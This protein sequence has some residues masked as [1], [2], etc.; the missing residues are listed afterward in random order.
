VARRTLRTYPKRAYDCNLQ[1]VSGNGGFKA[2][3]GDR[4]RVSKKKSKKIKKTLSKRL[5]KL[6]NCA[7]IKVQKE[8]EVH[9]ND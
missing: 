3:G 8:R 1:L 4:F 7:I 2:R 6:S 9:Q 5:T